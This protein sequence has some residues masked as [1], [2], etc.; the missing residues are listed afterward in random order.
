[1]VMKTILIILLLTVGHEVT[2]AQSLNRVVPEA[3]YAA[4]AEFESRTRDTVTGPSG[5]VSRYQILPAIWTRYAGRLDPRNPVTALNCA[6]VIMRERV[7]HFMLTH[8]R[9]P[10]DVEWY[11]LWHRPARVD[12]PRPAER[13]RAQRFANLLITDL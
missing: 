4:L 13:A 10:T 3:L 2:S 1:M 7:G 11:L 5:E 6:T 9:Q 12:H 8:D